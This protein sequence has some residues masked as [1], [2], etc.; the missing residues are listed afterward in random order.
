MNAAITVR[1][2][3]DC[4]IFR[5]ERESRSRNQFPF[6]SMK[7]NGHLPRHTYNP[8]LG[9]VD[10]DPRGSW[11]LGPETTGLRARQCLARGMSDSPWGGDPSREGDEV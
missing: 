5:V 8:E 4:D 7:V 2:R 10:R 11:R 1:K 9:I 6:Y 3:L